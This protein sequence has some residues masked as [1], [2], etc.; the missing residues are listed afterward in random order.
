MV[1]SWKMTYFGGGGDDLFSAA[2]MLVSG[3]L[4]VFDPSQTWVNYIDYIAMEALQC[5]YHVSSYVNVGH[6]W[7]INIY[8]YTHTYIVRKCCIQ[9]YE[10]AYNDHIHIITVLHRML[11][12]T[13]GLHTGIVPRNCRSSNV[14]MISSLSS[15]ATAPGCK[16]QRKEPSAN[17]HPAA[18]PDEG[19]FCRYLAVWQVENIS[20]LYPYTWNWGNL[21][22]NVWHRATSSRTIKLVEKHWECEGHYKSGLNL[23]WFQQR[24][25]ILCGPRSAPQARIYRA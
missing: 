14:Q 4:K 16:G 13:K 3:S 22:Q 19:W 6:W 25:S 9:M 10:Y 8:I 5:T 1:G 11:Y 2:I 12:H 15:H 18:R 7:V 24:G 23:G 17:V 21:W 20:N